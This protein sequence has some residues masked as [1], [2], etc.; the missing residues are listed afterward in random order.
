ML[1]PS[2]VYPA[3]EPSIFAGVESTVPP[4]RHAG[5]AVAKPGLTAA[6]FQLPARCSVSAL[7]NGTGASRTRMTRTALMRTTPDC[8]SR[9]GCARG[10]LQSS[11]A[12]IPLC[13]RSAHRGYRT[14][15][16][17]SRTPVPTNHSLNQ[18]TRSVGETDAALIQTSAGAAGSKVR[19]RGAPAAAS[20][21]CLGRVPRAVDRPA[22]CREGALRSACD[23]AAYVQVGQELSLSS[24]LVWR[25]HEQRS[26]RQT[27]LPA[28]HRG[29]GRARIAS[30]D[31]SESE[32]R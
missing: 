10:A 22:G 24:R 9:T 21:P 18:P 12:D 15:R 31:G 13:W 30:R 32:F 23:C 4:G 5:G 14:H 28:R 27:E 11:L 20:R 6:S 7:M 3:A 25:P 8:H 2:S 17:F 16:L 26:S 19:V 1:G 29:G